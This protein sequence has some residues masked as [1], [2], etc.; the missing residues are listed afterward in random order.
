MGGV[1]VR[2]ATGEVEEMGTGEMTPHH[3]V[4][5]VSAGLAAEA[6]VELVEAEALVAQGRMAGRAVTSG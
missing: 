5:G 3:Q 1:A 6:Q 2:E 4:L